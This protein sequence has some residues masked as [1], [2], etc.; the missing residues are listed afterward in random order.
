MKLTLK[1]NPKALTAF[2]LS[3][4]VAS[5]SAGTITWNGAGDGASWTDG[6]NWGGTA[7]ADD[8]TTDVAQW[9]GGVELDADRSVFGLDFIGGAQLTDTGDDNTLTLG[10]GGIDVTG[11][12]NG[13]I[14]SD[15]IF[16]ADTA[17]TLSNRRISFRSTST[18][19]GAGNV[20]ITGGNIAYFD[21][22]AST[23]TGGTTVTGGA[24]ASIK[25]SSGLGSGTVT[26][27]NGTVEDNNT[28][29][30]W[31]NDVIVN[32]G[33][34]TLNFNGNMSSTYTGS[35]ALRIVGSSITQDKSTTADGSGHSGGVT[36]DNVR[37]RTSNSNA[38]GTG[39]ITLANNAVIKNNNNNLNF[40][41]DIVIDSTGG[42]IEVGWT[43]RN[44]TLS[45]DVSGDGLL[46]VTNDSSVLR[47]TGAA[48]S[49]TG[50]TEIQGTVWADS[51]NLGTGSVTLNSVS[52][53]RGKLQNFNG[54]DTFAND[55]VVNA[56]NGGRLQAGWNSNLTLSG[57]I[58]GSGTLRISEDSGRVV[59]S[60]TANTFSGDIAFD[61]ATSR[62]NVGSLE[63]GNYTGTISGAGTIQYDLAGTQ[64]LAST[65][66]ISL[67]G[68]S[69]LDSGDLQVNTDMSSSAL[70]VRDGATVSGIGTLGITT[71]EAGGTISPGQSPGTLNTGKFTQLGVY[72]VEISSAASDQI[73]VTGSVDISG[74]SLSTTVLGVYAF[75]EEF[76][77]V[78]NDGT[79]A[80]T[81]TY[82]GLT[83]GAI[84]DSAPERGL[85]L[86]IF[87]GG[88]D[89]ND[90]ALVVIPEP[91][92]IALL[93]LSGLGLF[94]RRRK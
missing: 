59:L 20:T 65:S 72:E 36:L 85:E 18:V 46:T 73:N 83:E 60:N 74:G 14:Y 28:G 68:S 90:I 63:S 4:L 57:V 30:N 84:V 16:A 79:D 45:G 42:Q 67:T 6:A 34:G 56:D 92:S 26:L 39:P 38:Y 31:G 82:S 75:G 77:I 2:T 47:L 55:I 5:L 89:G 12:G 33:G 94:A 27:D 10:G 54:A 41:N 93:A 32:A 9:G 7:P 37:F 29:F 17:I 87:Y 15:V 52:P 64:V 22:A 19:S 62:I 53:D 49:Y 24:R 76:I 21:V 81:G 88:G 43:N 25:G 58:S 70:F 48:N 78:N 61:G 69:V 35:G 86:A 40:S 1:R 80:V 91:S 23:R 44:I 50:G 51:G 66:T 8:I 13:D 71:I 3:S 11:G